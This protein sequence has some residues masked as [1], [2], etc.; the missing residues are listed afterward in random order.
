[1]KLAMKWRYLLVA[2][3]PSSKCLTATYSTWWTA[4]E[5]STARAQINYNSHRNHWIIMMKA[6]AMVGAIAMSNNVFMKK[7]LGIVFVFIILYCVL[8]VHSNYKL[9]SLCNYLLFHF[10]VEIIVENFREMKFIVV[11]SFVLHTINW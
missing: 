4:K 10:V 6:A 11:I 8:W 3:V 9:C 1:M 7:R 5:K 2:I